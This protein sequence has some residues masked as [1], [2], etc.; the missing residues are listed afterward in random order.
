M[1]L[2]LLLSL[3][4]AF[5]RDGINRDGDAS[6]EDGWGW[7]GMDSPGM[8]HPHLSLLIPKAIPFYPL[9]YIGYLSQKIQKLT[10]KTIFENFAFF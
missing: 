5:K 4:Q 8:A 9:C 3:Y 1:F 2:K 7:V 6:L 10:S